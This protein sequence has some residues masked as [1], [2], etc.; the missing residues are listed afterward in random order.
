M[1]LVQVVKQHLRLAVGSM[2]GV[3]NAAFGIMTFDTASRLF[4]NQ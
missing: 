1:V 3:F 4:P 2:E